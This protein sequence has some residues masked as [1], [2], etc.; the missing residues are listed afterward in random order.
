MAFRVY[1]LSS[2]NKPE[3]LQ[4]SAWAHPGRHRRVPVLGHSNV[5]PST[6]PELSSGVENSRVAVPEDGHSPPEN[7]G[8]VMMHSSS[9]P[10]FRQAKKRPWHTRFSPR[11][12]PSPHKERNC[13]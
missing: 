11:S 4:P 10:F 13:F 3:S 8:S 9:C 7:G 5:L 12:N 2:G 6:A 1:P